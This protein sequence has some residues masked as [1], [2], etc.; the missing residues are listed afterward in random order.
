[1][2]EHTR[3]ILGLPYPNL[4]SYWQNYWRQCIETLNDKDNVGF[5]IMGPRMVLQ[6]LLEELEGHGLSNQDNIDLFMRQISLLDKSDKVFYS[7]CHPIVSCLLQRL[8]DRS[9]RDTSIILCKR[10]LSTLSVKRYFTALVD[11]L[12]KTINETSSND[13]DNR[14]QINDITHLVIAEYVAEGFILEEIIK[15]ATEIPGVLIADGGEVIAAPSEYESIKKSDFASEEEYHRAIAEYIENR[16][17]VKCLE[18][19]KYYY[20]QDPQEA[21]FIVRLNGLK[22]IIDDKIGEINI[23]SPKVKRYI[24]HEYS[25]SDVETVPDDRDWVNAAIPIDYISLAQAKVCAKAQL[26]EVLDI[27]MLTYRTKTPVTMA[28]D[29]YAVVADGRELSCSF[30]AKDNDPQKSSREE[31]I[32]YLDSLD[33][34]EIKQD[35]FKFMS[36]KHRVLGVGQGALKRRLKNAA[37]WYSKAVSADKDVDVLL[38]SWFAIEGLLKM[39]SHTQSELLSKSKGANSFKAIQEFITSFI[40]KQYFRSY[41]RDTYRSIYFFTKHHNNFY[42]I[43][44]DVIRRAGLDLNPG[45][46]Y[47]D[48][49]FLNALPDIISCINDDIVKDK[50]IQL[51]LFY[52]D[53]KGLRG[54]EAQMREDLLMIYRLRNMI[55]HNAALSCVNIVFYAHEARFLAQRVIRYVI[56]KASKSNSIEE[57]ALETIVNYQLFAANYNEELKNL[58]NG[59]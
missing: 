49:D 10:V 23:Y 44:S 31:M 43:P 16:D 45:E 15:F 54:K 5:K 48:G 20:Y 30:S 27:L 19:L 13:F 46:R 14:K 32:Q 26:D 42:D 41:L 17:V 52:Q 51:Q 25:L 56:D 3:R 47:R 18:L 33:L 11:W 40:C 38:Y 58:K 12:A 53:D 4:Y 6:D 59:N 29:M 1:M 22:G 35:G 28:T 39:D 24:K 37:H 9:N 55:V 57:I 36:D 50:L 7:L 34:T 8:S 21:F 2:D